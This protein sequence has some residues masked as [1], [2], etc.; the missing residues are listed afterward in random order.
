MKICPNFSCPKELP[1]LHADSNP[2]IHRIMSTDLGGILKYPMIQINMGKQ[3][4]SIRFSEGF[5]R[6]RR[7]TEGIFVFQY[8]EGEAFELFFQRWI[9]ELYVYQFPVPAE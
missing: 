1:F 2:P 6:A 8:Q 4:E 5:H 3:G 9:V 7:A